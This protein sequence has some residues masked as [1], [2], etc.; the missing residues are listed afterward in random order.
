MAYALVN[1]SGDRNYHGTVTRFLEDIEH[2]KVEGVVLVAITK[3]GPFV[4][5]NCSPM[6]MAASAAI[7]QA[8]TNQF[9]QE[10]M[11]D[12]EDCD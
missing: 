8:Q 9:Y 1:T 11:H 2:E 7:L 6:H 12:E 4:S 3:R 10:A 5:W